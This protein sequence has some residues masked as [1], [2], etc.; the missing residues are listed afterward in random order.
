MSKI[1]EQGADAK[2][3]TANE[4]ARLQLISVLGGPMRR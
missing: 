3:A 2:R 4:G 1:A